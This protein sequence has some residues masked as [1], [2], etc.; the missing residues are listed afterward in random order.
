MTNDKCTTK[1]LSMKAAAL[2]RLN[3]PL[4]DCETPFLPFLI[5]P[6]YTQLQI[7]YVTE[8]KYVRFGCTD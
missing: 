4:W 6:V 7:I 2:E 8:Q 5:I 3:E 1:A